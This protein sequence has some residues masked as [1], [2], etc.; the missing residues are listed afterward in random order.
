[1]KQ[2][3]I[4]KAT[5][6][7][8]M[9][10]A[11]AQN[12]VKDHEKICDGISYTDIEIPFLYTGSI[13]QKK[14]IEGSFKN[15]QK[16]GFWLY[17]DDNGK[18]IEKRNHKDN[19]TFTSKFTPGATTVMSTEKNG[20]K[21]FHHVKNEDVAWSARFYQFV[22]FDKMVEF[23]GQLVKNALEDIVAR[24]KVTFFS[25]GELK[26]QI[27]FDITQLN[28]Y[29]LV[30][31]LTKNDLFV[32]KSRLITEERIIAIQLIGKNVQTGEL[33]VLPALYYPH[34]REELARYAVT[35]HGTKTTVDELFFHHY[36]RGP[37]R[38]FTSKN[39]K[40]YSYGNSFNELNCF[41]YKSYTELLFNA[42]T[43][44][45]D[46]LIKRNQ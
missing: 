41:A 9:Q 38:Q 19:F 44:L 15:G 21:N 42:E 8:S 43:Y 26:E 16:S 27:S 10:V 22:E 28:N 36:F 1:M 31:F 29:K 23:D 32:D 35:F 46:Y 30:G 37:I 12:T 6:V 7:L 40:S 20:L 18:L 13:E 4:L 45:R 2:G 11:F 39:Q 17:Y 3:L 33:E 25:D 24:N 5:F 34:I 14:V